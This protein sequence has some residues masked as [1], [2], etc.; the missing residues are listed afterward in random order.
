MPSL[1]LERKNNCEG[2]NCPAYIIRKKE[3]TRVCVCVRVWCRVDEKTSTRLAT[4]KKSS[5]N[6]FF[7]LVIFRRS[8]FERHVCEIFIKFGLKIEL[9][10]II[11]IQAKWRG[12]PRPMWLSLRI[13]LCNEIVKLLPERLY[14][15]WLLAKV[16]FGI[17]VSRALRRTTANWV[18]E[19][20]GCGRILEKLCGSKAFLFH[21]IYT[22]IEAYRINRISFYDEGLS[23]TTLLS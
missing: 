20:R 8:I 7:F 17:K 5:R 15:C 11:S 2:G 3:T 14:Y 12:R 22:Y 21:L 9:E 18:V 13:L 1:N 19:G 6:F 23:V 16:S 10:C 4:Q